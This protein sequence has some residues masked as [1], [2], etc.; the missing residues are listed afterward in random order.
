M[1]LLRQLPGSRPEPPGLERIV[2]RWMPTT[3]LAGTVLPLLYA[4]GARWLIVG[5]DAFEIAK[6]IQL[7][8]YLALGLIVFHWSVVITVTIYCLIVMLMK[9]PAYVADRY[10][11]PD[12]PAPH[13]RRT[14]D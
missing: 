8:D 4:L 5:D 2:L 6:Q 1:N 10:D 14:G 11:L 9:G 13:E 7:N 12:A 3:L